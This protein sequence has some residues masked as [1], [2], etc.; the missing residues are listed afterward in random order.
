M[1]VYLETFDA[2]D[3]WAYAL[4]DSFQITDGTDNYRLT[5]SGYSGTAGDGMTEFNTADN[6]QFSTRDNDLRPNNCPVRFTGAWWYNDCHYACLNGQY[7]WGEHPDSYADG[8][9][10]IPYRLHHYSMKTTIMKVQ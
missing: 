2:T 8:V 3:N 9:N 6:M 4:Y 10:W 7:L 1:H 5:L